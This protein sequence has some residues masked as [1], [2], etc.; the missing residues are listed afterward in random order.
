[1]PLSQED[2]QLIETAGNII[3][4]NYDS[5]NWLHTVGAA[6]RARNGK[7]YVGVNCDSVSHGACAE[8]IAI[9][10]AITAGEREFDTIVAVLGGKTGKILPPCGNCRQ[11]MYL[12]DKNMNVIVSEN[13]KVNVLEL[14][15]YPCE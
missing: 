10:S 12:Y 5:V 11:M 8:V 15:K 1:M 9:G 13:T 2:K 14:L 4:E 7:V 6:V 3:G